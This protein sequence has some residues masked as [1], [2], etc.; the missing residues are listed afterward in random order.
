MK[1]ALIGTA[2][3]LLLSAC[4]YFSQGSIHQFAF[5]VSAAANVLCWLL[6]F[7]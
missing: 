6:I 7:A 2:I 3:S 5:Y 4:L 1:Q